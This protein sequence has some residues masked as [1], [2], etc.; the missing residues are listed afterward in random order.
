MEMLPFCTEE[1]RM[2]IYSEENFSCSSPCNGGTYCGQRIGYLNIRL[3]S[4]SH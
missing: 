4:F 1:C 3:D 2:F